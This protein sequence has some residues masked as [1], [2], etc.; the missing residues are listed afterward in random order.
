M[1]LTA[2]GRRAAARGRMV[3]LRYAFRTGG[4]FTLRTRLRLGGGGCFDR[5]RAQPRCVGP[6][7]S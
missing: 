7:G 1:R 2:A 5:A 6:S 3:E 4:R